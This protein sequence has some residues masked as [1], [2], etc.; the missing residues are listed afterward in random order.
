MT[1]ISKFRTMTHELLHCYE[2]P[3]AQIL[4]EIIC[5][6][7]VPMKFGKTLEILIPCHKTYLYV[8]G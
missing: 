7:L 4:V 6:T 3:C 8:M 1:L 2:D 5:S